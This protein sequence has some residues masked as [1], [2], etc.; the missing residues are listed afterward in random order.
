[1][2]TKKRLLLAGAAVLALL[3]LPACSGT[4]NTGAKQTPTFSAAR[5]I[6]IVAPQQQQRPRV[7]TMRPV[8]GRGGVIRPDAEALRSGYWV[9]ENYDP[10]H[11]YEIPIKFGTAATFL[12]AS[13]E[14]F[15]GAIGGKV[16]D[17]EVQPSY[18]G[19]RPTFSITP[20]FPGARGDL[21]VFTSGDPGLYRFN[22]VPAK[23]GLEVIDIRT[24]ANE[25]PAQQDA[26]ATGCTGFRPQ[27]DYTSLVAQRIDGEG[28]P[29][30]NPAESWADSTKLFVRFNNPLPTLPGLFAGMQG[31]QQVNYRTQS[32]AASTCIITD[33]RV[34]EFELRYGNER[35]RFG[36]DP[37]AVRAGWSASPG[38]G[39]QGAVALPP[40][41]VNP[42]GATT[43]APVG[44]NLAV[45]VMPPGG[46][47]LTAAPEAPAPAVVP[48]QASEQPQP[49][50]KSA[51]VHPDRQPRG[52]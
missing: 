36:V 38:Q 2:I 41:P 1:M 31:E 19:A 32:D 29:P 39:W 42:F 16:I 27:G 50:K 49:P 52:V 45:I 15:N 12:M 28:V 40:E 43:E 47:A 51:P 21:K 20:R 26:S 7:T 17:F 10:A 25:V 22:L 37:S 8:V 9:L 35:L 33:R 23:S 44:S 6:P 48:A 13:G 24:L 30:W 4:V 11:R 5:H 18:S 3:A 34:T 46:T 14:Q